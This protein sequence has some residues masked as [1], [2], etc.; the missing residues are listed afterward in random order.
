MFIDII[1]KILLSLTLMTTTPK[2]YITGHSWAVGTFESLD[3]IDTIDYKLEAKTG[4]SM[5]WSLRRIKRLEQNEYT[6]I[7]IFTGINDYRNGNE[8]IKNKFNELITESFRKVSKVYLFNIPKYY[9]FDVTEINEYLNG[10]QIE[11]LIILDVCS[12][13]ENSNSL[14]PRSYFKAKQL[15]LNSIK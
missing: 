14:H 5:D 11:G 10:L 2:Y 1:T 15:F 3:S 12:E 6:A 9:L 4:A 8:F 7:V 13:Y